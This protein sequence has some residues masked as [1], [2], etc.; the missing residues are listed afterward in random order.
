MAWIRNTGN[1]RT[2]FGLFVIRKIKIQHIGIQLLLLLYAVE[3]CWANMRPKYGWNSFICLYA[4]V[5]HFYSICVRESNRCQNTSSSFVN[6]F[7]FHSCRS[8]SICF[9]QSHHRRYRK[10]MRLQL[11]IKKSFPHARAQLEYIVVSSRKVRGQANAITAYYGAC[12]C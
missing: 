2:H 10:S 7:H 9:A 5:L 1:V 4:M 11:S 3:W 8:S 6:L 12:T